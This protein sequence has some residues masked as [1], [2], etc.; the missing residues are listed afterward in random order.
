MSNKLQQNAIGSNDIELLKS[1]QGNMLNDLNSLKDDITD[2]ANTAINKASEDA[3]TSNATYPIVAE[4]ARSVTQQVSTSNTL[5]NKNI[6]TAEV[7]SVTGDVTTLTQHDS[8]PDKLKAE[9]NMIKTL[10]SN[11]TLATKL[12]NAIETI[13][14]LEKRWLLLDSVIEQLSNNINNNEQYGRLY[15][16]M[17]RKVKNV[18]TKL[19]GIKFSEYIVGLLNALLGNYLLRQVTMLDIDKSHPLFVKENGDYTLIVRF[20]NRD[21]RDEIF[22]KKKF[23]KGSGIVITENLTRKNLSLL[24][25][26]RKELGE[27]SAWSD[28]G[29]ILTFLNGRKHVI[30][31]D[32][33]V[34]KI[35]SDPGFKPVP[36]LHLGEPTSDPKAPNSNDHARTNVLQSE[37]GQLIASPPP[38]NYE[39][40]YPSI[41]QAIQIQEQY[42][43]RGR[44]ESALQGNNR[45]ISDGTHHGEKT[46][47]GA[48]GHNNYYRGSN[49]N[50]R[51]RGRG[52][53]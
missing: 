46:R 38:S 50:F 17:I 35:K 42:G 47:K 9:Q 4:A 14:N 10:V 6:P 7:N 13:N 32:A 34:Y 48:A 3:S 19:V 33:H 12:N 27:R 26:A 53:R 45:P 25:L 18:P 11:P 36:E 2:I 23:L 40:L 44:L 29:R 37:D 28:Q 41:S 21:I 15:N 39:Q 16:L 52:K 8:T 30:V 31:S 51:G 43:S 1:C 5:P 24:N 49:K 22:Y 20:T